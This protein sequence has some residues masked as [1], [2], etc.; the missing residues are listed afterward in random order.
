M[1]HNL[2]PAHRVIVHFRNALILDDSKL[3]ST[4]GGAS[5][6][7]FRPFMPSDTENLG[8][9]VSERNGGNFLSPWSASRLLAEQK[10]LSRL[11]A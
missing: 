6:F 7:Y 3:K 2:L 1:H 8:I 4:S 9:V 5:L 10:A 11:R